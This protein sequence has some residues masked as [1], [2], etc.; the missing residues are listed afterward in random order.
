MLF[1]ST[2]LDLSLMQQITHNALMDDTAAI[3]TASDGLPNTFVTF[4]EMVRKV[5]LTIE[6]WTRQRDIYR[7]GDSSNPLELGFSFFYLNRTNRSGILT[8][9]VI[10][11]LNQVGKYKMDARFNKDAL[12]SRLKTIGRL[13]SSITVSNF[14]R[15]TVVRNCSGASNVL[16]YID[17]PYVKAGGRLYLNSFELRDHKCLAQVVNEI[18]KA[19]WIVTYD[20]SDLI[21]EMYGKFCQ[22]ALELT[23]SAQKPGKA[24]ELLIVSDS[25]ADVLAP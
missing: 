9:G 19:N 6:E 21:V 5:P 8:G 24:T 1:R 14:D 20:Q 25:I 4:V 13:A 22:C 15:R 17:P 16:M 2:V 23:Y 10:G 3:E 12:V 18:D 7:T 11:G